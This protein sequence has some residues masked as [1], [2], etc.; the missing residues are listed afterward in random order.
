MCTYMDECRDK[1]SRNQVTAEA[2]LSTTFSWLLGECDI[3]LYGEW[4]IVLA[5]ELLLDVHSFCVVNSFITGMY[6]SLASWS[7]IILA[8]YLMHATFCMRFQHI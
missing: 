1:S 7:A 3:N 5:V 4:S 8:T 2:C 6:F